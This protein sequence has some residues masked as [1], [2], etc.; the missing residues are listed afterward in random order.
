MP[1]ITLM[2]STILRDAPL[3]ASMV[4]TTFAHH[5]ATLHRHPGRAARQLIGLLGIVGV[6][7][8]GRGQL[9]HHD[10]DQ[11]SIG[12]GLAQCAGQG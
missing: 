12:A 5:G 8:Y 6:L 9:R 2:M 7:A 3:M 1:S 10:T 4:R 11:G